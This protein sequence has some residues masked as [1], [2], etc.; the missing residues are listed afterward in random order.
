[1]G[2]QAY[3]RATAGYVLL[4]LGCVFFFFA[5]PG[6]AEDR[7][8]LWTQDV[9]TE[10]GIV[11]DDKKVWSRLGTFDSK[12]ACF[13]DASAKAEGLAYGASEHRKVEVLRVGLGEDQLAVKSRFSG[14]LF[15]K[16]LLWTYYRCL[17]DTVVPRPLK[18]K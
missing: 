1:M 5:Q 11:A 3:F 6:S 2:R 10:P 18:T 15:D 7:W 4:S 8:V 9:A 16:A 13:T 14:G 12:A 17:P